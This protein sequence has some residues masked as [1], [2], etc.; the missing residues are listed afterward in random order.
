VDAATT[1]AIARLADAGFDLVHAFDVAAAAREPGWEFLADGSLGVGLLVCNTRA[2][3][4]RFVAAMRDPALEADRDP[5]DRY[6]ERTIE[7]AFPGAPVYFGHRE[8]GRDFAQR[9][10]RE[11][12]QRD[13]RDSARRDCSGS[14]QPMEGGAFLPFT[15]LAVATGLGGL[16]AS[17]LVIHPIYGPWFALRAVVLVAGDPPVRA[18]TAPACACGSPCKTA[19]VSALAST[20]WEAWLAVRDACSLRA[21]RYSDEQIRYHYT[22]QWIPPVET[23]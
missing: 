11:R 16:A 23:P 17:N 10:G 3:W 15:R 7:A 5:L 18:S 13:Q 21:W 2:L 1:A 9:D 14:A 6:T 19:L 22:K 20:S 12:P 4:P 8:Y